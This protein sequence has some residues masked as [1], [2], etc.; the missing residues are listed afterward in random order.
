MDK[1]ANTNKNHEA[2][3]IW[4][5]V[6]HKN[7][8]DNRAVAA[9]IIRSGNYEKEE[10][11][12]HATLDALKSENPDLAFQN[13]R[14]YYKEAKEREANRIVKYIQS[15][16]RINPLFI[17]VIRRSHKNNSKAAFFRENNDIKFAYRL[18]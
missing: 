4:E 13:L 14:D 11:A 8:Y 9:E 12:I 7:V 18:R 2:R 17:A 1:L 6:P 15:L 10:T 16:Y 5:A 3:L